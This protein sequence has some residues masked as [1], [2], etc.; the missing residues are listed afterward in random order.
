MPRFEWPTMPN[1]VSM[2]HSQSTSTTWSISET[3]G[4]IT[5]SST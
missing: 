4:S 3:R 2:P 1:T 5:G